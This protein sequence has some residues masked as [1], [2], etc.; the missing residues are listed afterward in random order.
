MKIEDY[1]IFSDEDVVAVN[2]P[3]GML[4]IPDREG[5]GTSLKELLKEKFGEIFTV[6]RLDRDTSGL[7]IVGLI[8]RVSYNAL[9]QGGIQ[10]PGMATLLIFPLMA[11][12]LM[13]AVQIIATR[14]NM[15]KD[16][17][18]PRS[19]WPSPSMIV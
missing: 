10:S 3:S 6:H 5:K 19:M 1:I 7:L 16:D 12:V 4:S 11:G 15:P 18:V 17:P 8:A 13:V 14:R 9:D 2:K